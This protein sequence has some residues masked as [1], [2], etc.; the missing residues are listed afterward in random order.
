[1]ISCTSPL[2][3]AY[4]WQRDG[5]HADYLLAD[6]HTCIA[7]PDELSY[8]DG[9][10]IACGLGTAYE[11]LTRAETSGRDAVLVVGLGPVGLGAALLA[12][13][14]GAWSGAGVDVAAERLEL[15]RTIAA[16]D[17]ALP[18]EDAAPEV[19]GRYDVAID[20]SGSAAGRALAL[21][22]TRRHGR[23]V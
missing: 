15:A 22:G 13:A 7:L 5:G 14:L 10:C 1:M 8:L 3:A 11:A 6:E 4:G 9:A 20:C 2:R 12:R 17:R 19:A 16:V 21:S 23:C 18:A